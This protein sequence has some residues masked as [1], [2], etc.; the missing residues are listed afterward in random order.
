M[1]N[2]EEHKLIAEFLGLDVL[3]GNKVS[4]KSTKTGLVTTMKYHTSWDWL[5]PVVKQIKNLNR[6]YKRHYNHIDKIDQALID[7][8]I[9]KL[10]EIVVEFIKW[11][12]KN[13][14]NGI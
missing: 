2:T 9:N 14:N 5:M 7:V 13:K 3:Y 11:Y 4:H 10:F 8:N 12:N 6:E 1:N